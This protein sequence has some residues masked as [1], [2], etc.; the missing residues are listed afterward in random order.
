MLETERLH[1]KPISE[2]HSEVINNEIRKSQ[3]TLSRWLFWART[4]PD[5]DKTRDFCRECDRKFREKE[6]LEMGIFNKNDGAFMGCIG[7][8]NFNYKGEEKS[9]DIGYWIGAEYAR[10][11]YML[12]ALKALS[13]YAFEELGAKKLSITTDAENIASNK[14]ALKAGFLLTDTIEKDGT[15]GADEERNTNIYSQLR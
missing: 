7:I 13:H 5:L 4:L 10:Q 8:H 14:L 15:Y 6:S 2:E 1:I 11:G 3:P 12:E 9:F